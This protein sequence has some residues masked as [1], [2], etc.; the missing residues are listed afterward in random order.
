[1]CAEERETCTNRT[2]YLKPD[3]KCVINERFKA[4]IIEGFNY[5]D[6]LNLSPQA[7]VWK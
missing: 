2:Y 6:V 7:V 4:L 5:E 1:M 3:I